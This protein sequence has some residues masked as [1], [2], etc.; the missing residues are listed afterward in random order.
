MDGGGGPLT[1]WK[2][3][4]VEGE[5]AFLSKDGVL[6]FEANGRL[7]SG[8]GGSIIKGPEIVQL[9][10]RTEGDA[11]P[12]Q[13]RNSTLYLLRRHAIKQEEFHAPTL[14]EYRDAV[15]ELRQAY[16][17]LAQ[18]RGIQFID[19]MIAQVHTPRYVGLRR[20]RSVS[21]QAILIACSG[22]SQPMALLALRA[23]YELTSPR[24]RRHASSPCMRRSWKERP[25][26]RT[27]S[28]TVHGK[29]ASPTVSS[30]ICTT[31]M[32]ALVL[33]MPSVALTSIT[34][35]RMQ[36]T[37]GCVRTFV[38]P[39][40]AFG[41]PS[42]GS[43]I[44]ETISDQESQRLGHGPVSVSYLSQTGIDSIEIRFE[45]VRRLRQTREVRCSRRLIGDSCHGRYTEYLA[46]F[47][48]GSTSW[49]PSC[50][51]ADDLKGEFWDVVT[52]G[53]EEVTEIVKSDPA[54][55]TL[56]VKRADGREE[57]TSETR[58]FWQ[59]EDK[60]A[61]L[62]DVEL[63]SIMHHTHYGVDYTDFI[64]CTLLVEADW[65]RVE[66]LSYGAM[67]MQDPVAAKTGEYAGVRQDGRMLQLGTEYSLKF[68]SR[69][70]S[71][72]LLF[73]HCG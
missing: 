38:I 41:K 36:V 71:C 68:N 17:E 72:V 62:S 44:A 60:P 32:Y 4:R 67:I 52:A 42:L 61:M 6:R 54:Q 48:D 24:R 53:A 14:L 25:R 56:T 12:V 16:G 9:A 64:P 40:A 70:V 46:E 10:H 30:S 57:P 2:I 63:E 33:S 58:I 23:W 26:A 29:Q 59:P 66:L 13:L 34:I 65:A 39:A 49:I 18:G 47:G 5:S 73:V 31:N 19:T 3:F 55:G 20:N 8:I 7:F 51:V 45:P 35:L 28:R 21:S 43:K 22:T 37:Y 27:R 69:T 50:N 1:T 15:D 11:A